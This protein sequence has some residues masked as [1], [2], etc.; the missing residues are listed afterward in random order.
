M[1]K[2][3]LYLCNEEDTVSLHSVYDQSVSGDSRTTSARKNV[4]MQNKAVR[5]NI[6]EKLNDCSPILERINEIIPLRKRDHTIVIKYLI[7]FTSFLS[8]S[9]HIFYQTTLKS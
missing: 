6:S 9:V 1:I 8:V 4:T 2:K 3:R 5:I 7:Y